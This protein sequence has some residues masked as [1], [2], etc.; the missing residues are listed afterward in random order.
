MYKMIWNE[1]SEKNFLKSVK[2]QIFHKICETANFS[3]YVYNISFV[4]ASTRGWTATGSLP[5]VPMLISEAGRP[6]QVRGYALS[7]GTQ[8]NHADDKL[9]WFIIAKLRCLL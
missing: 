7:Q 9:Q 8:T 2:L 1:M 3:C 4:R 5:F 6:P